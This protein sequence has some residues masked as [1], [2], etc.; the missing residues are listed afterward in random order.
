MLMLLVPVLLLL[1]PGLG[2]MA[3]DPDPCTTYDTDGT[4]YDLNSLAAKY[5][6]LARY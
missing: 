1:F 4:F 3:K 2:A 6:G 5:I